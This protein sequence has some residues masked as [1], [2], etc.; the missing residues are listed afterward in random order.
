M[1][2]DNKLDH[3]IENNRLL[4]DIDEKGHIKSS[5]LLINYTNNAY[6]IIKTNENEKLSL[7]KMENNLCKIKIYKYKFRKENDLIY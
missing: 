7:W 6:D 2:A 1:I 4:P 5:Y 3:K